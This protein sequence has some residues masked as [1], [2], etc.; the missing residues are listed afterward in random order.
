[1]D[2]CRLLSLFE[3]GDMVLP[4]QATYTLGMLNMVHLFVW[5]PQYIPHLAAELQKCPHAQKMAIVQNAFSPQ[6]AQQ[7]MSSLP[8]RDSLHL[9][10]AQLFNRELEGNASLF[11]AF[12]ETAPLGSPKFQE[13]LARLL[14]MET[15]SASPR[16]RELVPPST[17]ARAFGAES[18]SAHQAF[19]SA[20][21]G[22]LPSDFLATNPSFAAFRAWRETED[23]SKPGKGIDLL[24]R[25]AWKGPFFEGLRE[26]FEGLRGMDRDKALSGYAKMRS[27]AAIDASL[28]KMIVGRAYDEIERM[29]ALKGKE[30]VRI[31]SLVQNM[32]RSSTVVIKDSVLNRTSI[33]AGGLPGT[34]QIC[35]YCGKELSFPKPPRFCPYC[36]EQLHL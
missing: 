3:R 32:D 7:M 19:W 4:S 20:Q 18:L 17:L 25:E 21:I 6:V 15:L 9:A 31:D 16:F 12:R 13:R 35:P 24:A 2:T 5:S 33:D 34:L 1:M 26:L 30:S 14:G 27:D 10:A 23:L 22:A 8:D 29:N 28:S 36:K 11:K